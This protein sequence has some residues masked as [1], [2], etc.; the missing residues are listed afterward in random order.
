M[1]SRRVSRYDVFSLLWR[2][3]R[4]YVTFSK[5][6]TSFYDAERRFLG[7]DW[8]QTVPFSK[9]V[10]KNGFF[11]FSFRWF[12]GGLVF[13]GFGISRRSGLSNRPAFFRELVFGI[14]SF[15]SSLFRIIG[16]SRFRNIEISK[17]R[18]I[19]LSSYRSFG[20]SS[21]RG[22]QALGLKKRKHPIGEDG[23]VGKWIC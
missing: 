16:F 5:H 18:R 13:V 6:R 23:A 10:R 20:L 14:L 1:K 21:Y 19:E 17:Y 7:P 9:S 2:I 8:E 15:Q 12:I 4:F 11:E 3:F 22:F